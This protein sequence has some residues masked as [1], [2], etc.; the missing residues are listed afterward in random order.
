MIG[1]TK[2]VN[3]EKK[4]SASPHL[5]T[6]L[7]SFIGTEIG[8]PYSD[9]A[10]KNPRTAKHVI[11][12]FWSWSPAHS[13]RS[14]Y[15]L[16]TDRHRK[17]WSLYE[18][19]INPETRKSLCCRVASGEPYK[20]ISAENA[21]YQLLL[22]TWN[23]EINQWDFDPKDFEIDKCGLLNEIDINR[24]I[25]KLS[26]ST[27]HKNNKTLK[28]TYTQ[29]TFQN[30]PT[31]I[32]SQQNQKKNNDEVNYWQKLINSGNPRKLKIESIIEDF[33]RGDIPIRIVKFGHQYDTWA[34]LSWLFQDPNKVFFALEK[35]AKRD[36]KIARVFI[37]KIMNSGASA[38]S[39]FTSPYQP[40]G[41]AAWIVGKFIEK[42]RVIISIYAQNIA[43]QLNI[44]FPKNL[45]IEGLPFWGEGYDQE[46]SLARVKRFNLE[47]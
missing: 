2:N 23:E 26:L 33:V 6:A 43:D 34:I 15:R 18:V 11:T 10:E 25:K 16:A 27:K 39:H 47:N 45:R 21:A 36:I 17:T 8:D 20:G 37:E 7:S 9:L 42:K 30:Y 32:D 4:I 12:L 44:C 24:I 5:F 46:L 19:T 40:S 14:E 29:L 28:A 41:G 35:L 1:N 3:K 13:R 31:Q 38:A 22:S